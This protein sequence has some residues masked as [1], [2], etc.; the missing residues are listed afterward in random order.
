MNIPFLDLRSINARHADELA[1][2]AR[3]VIDSGWYILGAEVKNFE[4]QF[5]R[6]NSQQHCIGVGDGLAAL[7]LTLRAWKE[8]GVLKTGDEVIVPAHTYIASILAI[9]E[10]DLKPVLVE[11]DEFFTLDVSSLENAMSRRTRA[12]MMVHLYGQLGDM[13]PLTEFCRKHNL[14]LL[15]D[16]AQAHGA[17]TNA[18]KAGAFS[19][20]GCFS[21]YPGKNLGA[22]GDGGAI[23]T[24]DGQ[25]AE[26]LRALRNYGSH[27]KYHNQYQGINSRLD[28]LQAAL[29]SV[30]LKYLDADNAARRKIASE[31]LVRIRNPQI[32]LPS[33]R[34]E[35]ESHVWHLFVVRTANRDALQRHLDLQ[36]VQTVIHYPVPPH[37]QDCY[38][39]EME[40]L[41]L[42]LTEA[43]HRE[44]LSLPIS[45]VMSRVEIDAVVQAV[46]CYRP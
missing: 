17:K 36:G 30:K 9:T 14:K 33:I 32:Q 5:A 41:S 44:V 38:R 37:R 35:A 2:A 6:W 21:F 24:D 31:Y 46:N 7:S 12:V 13:A 34:G 27:R 4:E 40:N 3:R 11:P 22:L 8:M 45:P 39:A 10:N 19:D 18:K 15:E 16:C 43:A 23:T 25:F 28:E 26:V 20:A 1:A 42:P 29:L